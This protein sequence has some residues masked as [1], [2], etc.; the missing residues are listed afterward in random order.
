MGLEGV[1]SKRKDFGLPLRPFLWMG[2][3]YRSRFSEQ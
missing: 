2:V 3:E 1:V